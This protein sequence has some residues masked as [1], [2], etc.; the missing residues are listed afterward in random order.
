MA[1]LNTPSNGQP[2]T[3]QLLNQIIEEINNIKQPEENV[4]EID[5]YGPGL[6]NNTTKPKIIFGKD[7]VTVPKD[8]TTFSGTA[9]FNSSFTNDSPI[10]IASLVDRQEGNG[11]QMGHITITSI[12]SKGFSYRI[13]LTKSRG[14][15]V[16]F[17]VNY[18]A[19]GATSK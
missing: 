1:R 15:D 10:V 19:L 5:V 13:R 6:N 11:V 12:S 18:I 3:Y 4:D 17:D 14:K 16:S 9:N 7:D 2:F 8:Q